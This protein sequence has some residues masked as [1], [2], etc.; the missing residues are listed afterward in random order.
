M[1]DSVDQAHDAGARPQRLCQKQGE[2]R[3]EH[4]AGDV[5]EEAAEGQKE[6][7]DGEPCQVLAAR[8][9]LLIGLV[10]RQRR[11]QN[12]VL[13]QAPWRRSSDTGLSAIHPSLASIA[14]SQCVRTPILS[15]PSPRASSPRKRR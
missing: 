8:E 3:V 12:I 13:P 14:M 10:R 1:R 9:P 11:M 2:Y 7:V 4:L 15:A 6:G 5:G